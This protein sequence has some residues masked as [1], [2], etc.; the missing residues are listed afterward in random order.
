MPCEPARPTRDR[1]VVVMLATD[2]EQLAWL[3]GRG[4]EVAVVEHDDREPGVAE[5]LG[6]CG[7]PVIAGGGEPVA[8]TTQGASPSADCS[9]R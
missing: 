7:Q 6:V 1:T 9:G 3:A 5:Y 4:A 8:I 2:V